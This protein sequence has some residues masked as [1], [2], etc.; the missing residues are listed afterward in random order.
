MP[1]KSTRRNAFTLVELLVVIGIIAVLISLLLPALNKAMAQARQIKCASNLHQLFVACQM[2]SDANKGVIMPSGVG[3]NVISPSQPFD[4]WP[5]LLANEGYVPVPKLTP[6]A[7]APTWFNANP[8][9]GYSYDS[10]FMCPSAAD[11]VFSSGVSDGSTRN[12]SVI[13]QPGTATQ[14]ALAVDSSYGMCGVSFDLPGV[15]STAWQADIYGWPCRPAGPV[16]GTTLYAPLSKMVQI[17]SP[18]RMCFLFDGG[19]LNPTTT[20]LT[21]ILFFDGHVQVYPRNTFPS[22]SKAGDFASPSQITIDV[23]AMVFRLDQT[24]AN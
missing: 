22:A 2:Y 12:I 21:N 13:L 16:A 23:P 8:A 10:I 20:G 17:Q 9:H 5:L 24:T 11:A 14:V 18:S 6:D 3:T 7:A 4:A 1:P 15:V 19:G